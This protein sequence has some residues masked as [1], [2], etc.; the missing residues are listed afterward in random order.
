MKILKLEPY[1]ALKRVLPSPG[2]SVKVIDT[3]EYI[4]PALLE[5]AAV[6]YHETRLVDYTLKYDLDYKEYSTFEESIMADMGRM[7]AE[8]MDKLIMNTL[9]GVSSANFEGIQPIDG[10]TGI[11]YT[12]RTDYSIDNSV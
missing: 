2:V 1:I 7:L 8:S 4:P 10:P 6:I 9:V 12:F 5:D 11:I 3:C